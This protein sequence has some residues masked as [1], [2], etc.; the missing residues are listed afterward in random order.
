MMHCEIGG[1]EREGSE[2]HGGVHPPPIEESRKK[3]VHLKTDLNA[4]TS[5][6]IGELLGE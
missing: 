4:L 3:P 2:H 6:P 5:A 1:A